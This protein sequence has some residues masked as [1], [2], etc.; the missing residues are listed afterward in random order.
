[1]KQNNLS[2]KPAFDFQRRSSGILMHLTSL[3]GPHGSGDLGPAAYHFIDFL[4]DAGQRWWQ[5]LPV[6]PHG[7]PPGFSPY[8]SASAFAGNPWL[9]SLDELVRQ[10]LLSADDL[11]PVKGLSDHHVN[12]LPMQRFREELLRKAFTNFYRRHGDTR[13]S[14]REFCE[15]NSDWLEDFALFAALRRESGGKPW[16]EWEND[17]SRREPVAL[18]AA[19]KRLED[20]I[21]IHRFVQF[22]FDR[23]W[24]ALK[25]YSHQQG[26]G[27]IGDLPIFL[28]HDSADVWTHQELFRLDTHGHSLRIS[29]YPPDRFNEKGQVWGHPQYD[30]SMHEKTGFNWWVRRFEHIYKRFDAVRI[31]HFLGFTRTWSIPAKAVNA[32]AGRWVKSPGTRLFRAIRQKLG[33]L[34]MIAEDLGHVT[35]ADIK[36]RDRFGL[37]PMRI[38]QFG[39]GT[40]PDSGDHLPHNYSP[41]CAAYTGNHDNDTVAGWFSDLDPDQQMRVLTYTGGRAGVYHLAAIRALMA[42]PARLVIFPVQDVLGLG[43]SARMNTPGTMKGNWSWRLQTIKSDRLSGQLSSMTELFGRKIAF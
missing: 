11:K 5:M 21:A 30:W 17:V 35:E 31:D 16:T 42:S 38:F 15:A 27:L 20:E 9:V 1:M 36:L 13:N 8:D 12:F 43:K 39:F 37:A 32:K 29:G 26:I 6:G 33:S 2:P 3:P 10:G 24:I 22:E 25:K 40:E 28:S 34:P 41:L 14:Y 4:S 23:Q 7:R 18:F 19:R